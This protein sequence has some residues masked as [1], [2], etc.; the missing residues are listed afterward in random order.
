MIPGCKPGRGCL[1]CELPPDACNHSGRKVFNEERQMIL[2]VGR[3][4]MEHGRPKKNKIKD[5]SR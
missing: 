4:T 1:T 3:E 2:A 5:R